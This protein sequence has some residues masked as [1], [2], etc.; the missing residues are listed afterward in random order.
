MKQLLLDNDEVRIELQG[1]ILFAKWKRSLAD[2]NSAQ[3]AVK[4]RLECTNFASFPLLL[5]VKE[6]KNITKPA[7]DFLASEKGCEGIIAGAFLI[8]SSIGRI[9]GNFIIHINRPLIPTKIFTKEVKAK[10]WLSKYIKKDQK[11]IS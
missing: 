9:I 7:R 6:L 1:G 10:K 3:Q 2:L 8:N 11:T 4:H 5:D